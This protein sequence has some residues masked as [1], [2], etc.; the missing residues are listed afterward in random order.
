MNIDH[1]SNSVFRIFGSWLIVQAIYHMARANTK[2]A[3][4]LS[5]KEVVLVYLRQMGLVFAVVGF[6]VGASFISSIHTWDFFIE[7]LLVIVVP[8][9]FG[10]HNGLVGP[11]LPDRS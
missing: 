5:R 3:T 2:Q 7:A 8:A 10:I 9:L 6:V 1:I 4:S 11:D